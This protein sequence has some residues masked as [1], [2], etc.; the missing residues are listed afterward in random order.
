[1]AQLLFVATTDVRSTPLFHIFS[2]LFAFILLLL[3]ALNAE[4][5]KKKKK[6][7]WL[8]C[9]W[10]NH[11]SQLHNIHCK[12]H[13]GRSKRCATLTSP[14]AACTFTFMVS[15]MSCVHLSAG[16]PLP[17]IMLPITVLSKPPWCLTWS[18][19][20]SFQDI[21]SFMRQFYS[22]FRSWRMSSLFTV[23]FKFVQCLCGI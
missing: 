12:P 7:T 2:L 23:I 11:T 5:Y 14:P 4:F 8:F 6:K 20:F 19:H 15:L 10:F 17:V 3:L 22:M 13:H 1:M 16:L 18:K 9:S 21:M